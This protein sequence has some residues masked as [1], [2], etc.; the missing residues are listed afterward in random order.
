M[1]AV[2]NILS[3]A[4]ALALFTTPLRATAAQTPDVNA[5]VSQLASRM[6]AVSAYKAHIR[7]AVQLHSFPYLA[8]NLEGTTT[9]SRPGHYSVTFDSL[10]S[11]ASAFQKVS[12]DVGDP[13]AWNSKYDIA[14]DTSQ[15]TSAPNTVALR[16]T[17]KVKGQ[18]DHA[19]AYV[20]L[21]SHT[22]TRMEWFYANGGRIAME[23][24]FA[25][26]NGV[27]LVD[28]QAADIDMPGYRATANAVFDGYNIQVSMNAGARINGNH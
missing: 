22:V 26:I 5:V 28:T 9:Y 24:H 3:A 17:E 16:L 12:G 13:A 1:N 20:D 2:R 14:V 7:L 25:P 21:D 23:Q 11:L 10:P 8:A 18:V 15:Q 27:L 6:D 19:L 4:A